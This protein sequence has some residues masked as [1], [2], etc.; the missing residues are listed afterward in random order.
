MSASGFPSFGVYRCLHCVNRCCVPTVLGCGQ[1]DLIGHEH[2]C[3]LHSL[4]RRIVTMCAKRVGGL[5]LSYN[6]LP[7]NKC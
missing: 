6:Q 7:V 1:G 5:C 3:Q 2:L 4:S